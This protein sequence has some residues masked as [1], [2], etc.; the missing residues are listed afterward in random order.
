MSVLVI[1]DYIEDVYRYG[2]ASRLC[3][4]APVPVVTDM[5]KRKITD[6]GAGLVAAQLRALRVPTDA[7]YGSHS[8]KERIFA[9]RHLI[10][11]I[12][13]DGDYTNEKEGIT[14]QMFLGMIRGTID[15]KDTK[16]VIVSDYD[17]GTMTENLAAGVIEYAAYKNIPVFADSKN[18]W[19]W[20]KGAF[21]IFPN[22]N[23][24]PGII[25]EPTTH[26]IRKM[27]GKGC[28]VD[29]QLV[30]GASPEAV[31]VTGAGDIF[32]AAFSAQFLKNPD[33][34][35][36]AAFANLVAGISVRYVGTHIVK[37]EEI[38]VR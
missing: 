37:P 26:I 22:Q 13:N 25:T 38:N 16:L 32:L 9:D 24:A 31:D 20:Y 19:D 36:A 2:T 33:L 27:G 28:L 12:D 15:S 34:Y 11:R 1:G 23:E 7:L 3:P 30:K 4:E 5:G 14:D 17:K 6:G 10:V 8:I 21:A 18:T 29:G 35:E